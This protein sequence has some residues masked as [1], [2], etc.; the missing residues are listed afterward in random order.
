MVYISCPHSSVQRTQMDL[1]LSYMNVGLAIANWR[2]SCP[3][4]AAGH[5]HMVP[6]QARYCLTPVAGPCEWMWFPLILLHGCFLQELVCLHCSPL[7]RCFELVHSILRLEHH[8]VST[9]KI[10]ATRHYFA[11][12]A[13]LMYT[14][15]LPCQQYKSH[16]HE[17]VFCTF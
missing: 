4:R 3:S 14:P 1:L 2:Y 15:L 16:F 12:R 11:H 10:Q 6:T 8:P 17:A 7:F 9:T 5:T 13:C